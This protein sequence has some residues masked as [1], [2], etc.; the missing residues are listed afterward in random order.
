MNKTEISSRLLVLKPALKDFFRSEAFVN[1]ILA[2]S[3]I[4]IGL[5]LA[6][7]I[8]SGDW[9]VSLALLF[10][11]PGIILLHRYPYIS[12]IVWM[13]LTPFLIQ[14]PTS[15]ERQIYWM[16][17][18]GLPI[19]TLG[20]MVISSALHI[21][22]R[23]LPRLTWPEIAIGLYVF[24]TIF[25]IF[26][27]NPDPLQT[28]YHFY[29]RF[30]SPA[31][32]YLIIRFSSP[33]EKILRWL[34]PVTLFITLSQFTIGLLS[35]VA[36]DLLPSAWLGYAGVRT[37]G[38][39]NSVSVY[40]TTLIFCGL[41][42]LNTAFTSRIR[43]QRMILFFAVLLTVYSIFISYSRASWLAGL[44]ALF[45]LMH[46]YPRFMIRAGLISIP[47]FL[48]IGST[49]LVRELD[50]ATERLTSPQAAYSALSRLPV[51]MAAYRMFEARP[52]LGWGY[53]N[54]ER[55]D[56]QFQTRVG[57]L[58]NPDEKDHSLHNVYLTILAEQGLVGITLFFTPLVWW[59]LRSLKAYR[60]LGK[61][62]FVNKKLLFIMW[63]V[64]VCH[65]VVNNFAPIVVVFGLGMWWITLGLIANIV[66][67]CM[68]IR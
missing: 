11:V 67:S 21:N 55:Y 68:P 32:L 64:I 45:G 40:S 4:G 6:R 44:I 17:H 58:V 35:W 26:Y 28:F 2:I 59:F 16:I 49:L 62:G 24:L 25:T 34:V 47:F 57:D 33:G 3:A 61:S 46:L 39:L 30:I 29:D 9:H 23:S 27:T 20:I 10:A 8:V 19:L 50:T 1:I 54:F 36:P 52:I 48:I 14:T 31:C 60:W 37:T 22:K 41:Y 13:M 51:F 63:L 53:G 5:V 38:S 65:M 66:Q 43:I 15:L 7:L 42:L 56:R 18:R 12:V